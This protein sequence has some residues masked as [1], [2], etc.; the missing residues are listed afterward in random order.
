[1]KPFVGIYIKI[2]PEQKEKMKNLGIGAKKI[3][4]IGYEKVMENFDKEFDEI[5]KN[6]YKK[7]IQVYT[8]QQEMKQKKAEK[9]LKNEQDKIKSAIATIKNA[10]YPEYWINKDIDGIKITRDFYEKHIGV[11]KK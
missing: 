10:E 4:E 5:V 11:I 6:R 3:F 7:Y 1:M 2:T 8:K 9:E